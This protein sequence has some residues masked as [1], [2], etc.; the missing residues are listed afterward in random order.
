[1]IPVLLEPLYKILTPII[2]LFH[3]N[4]DWYIKA[5]LV[6][7]L[8]YALAVWASSAAPSRGWRPCKSRATKR[9]R[10]ARRSCLPRTISCHSSP[11]PPSRCCWLA[12]LIVC[13]W[14]F[15]WV[16]GLIPIFGDIVIAGLLWPIV[17]V[18]GLIMAVVLV[19]LVGWP[20]MYA[21]ISAEGSDSFDAISRSYS[22]VYQA[23]WHYLWYAWWPSAYGAVLVFFVGFMGSLIVYLGQMGRRQDAGHRQGQSRQRSRAVVP[24]HLRADIVRLA[25][26]ACSTTADSPNRK[27]GVDADRSARRPHE[28]PL[29]YKYMESMHVVQLR[30]RLC[31]CRSG[32][33]SSSCWLS[34]SATAISGRRHDHL[35]PDAPQ[36]GRH[37]HGRGAPGR[38]GVR[39]PFARPASP[40]AA[41]SDGARAGQGKPA[42]VEPPSLRTAIS[43]GAAGIGTVGSAAARGRRPRR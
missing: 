32:S 31:W 35:P 20:L 33:T 11:P 16:E 8:L 14:L 9:S 36:G 37:R 17:L 7:V 23:P 18:V 43:P 34:A 25:R 40:A 6:L 38:G 13:L 15:G 2:Y 4:A 27:P 29:D 19:G 1:M 21:T 5:Y 30:R 12:I 10:C 22:Y 24:V 42:M 28:I 41:G 39:R 3:R 26:S